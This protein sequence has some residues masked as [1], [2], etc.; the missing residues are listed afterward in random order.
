[1]KKKRKYFLS[2]GEE[3]PKRPRKSEAPRKEPFEEF[4]YLCIR[5]RTQ[6]RIHRTHDNLANQRN[7]DT[8]DGKHHGALRLLDLIFVSRRREVEDTRDH[9]PDNGDKAQNR[10]E[11]IH[12]CFDDVVNARARRSAALRIIITG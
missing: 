9:K 10:E 12:R 7:N 3:K 11:I 4:L 1:M 5:T 8:H 2:R 6:P